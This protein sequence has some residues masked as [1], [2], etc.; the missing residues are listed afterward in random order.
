MCP[1]GTVCAAASEAGGVV[2]NGMSLHARDGQNA[3]AAVVVSVDGRDFDGDPARAVAFQRRLEQAAFRAGGGGYR[4]P[5]ETVGSFLEGRGKLDTLRVQPT[6]PRGVTP[7]DL[8][9]LLPGE[10]SAALR[11]G[12]TAFGRKLAAYRAPDAVLT[13]LET[14]TSSPVRLPRNAETLQC[15]ALPLS[16]IH[17]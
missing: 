6:Y 1:G 2:T 4:A 16:L 3:N 7:C 15:T 11:Q 8:G 5:A 17:I 13:G 12:L 14:R 10:L 9:A